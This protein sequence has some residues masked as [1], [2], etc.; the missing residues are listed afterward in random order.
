MSSRERWRGAFVS[1]LLVAALHGCH[2]EPASRAGHGGAKRTGDLNEPGS[3]WTY[4]FED[5]GADERPGGFEFARTGGGPPG[6]WRV[7]A[8]EGAP[9]GAHVLEQ[10]DTSDDEMR[11]LVAAAEMPP[12]SDV[13][14]SVRARPVSG[15]VDQA[16]G[17]VLRYQDE[18]NYYLVRANALEHNVRLYHVKDGKRTQL[19]SWSGSVAPDQWHTLETEAV[20][21][22]LR[23]SFDDRTLIDAHDTTFPNR[24]RVG[25]WTKADSVSQFDDFTIEVVEP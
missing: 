19:R 21:D 5:D 18:S 10:S 7:V 2:G 3:T 17:L 14:V 1:T 4:D 20:G 25:L 12:V 23:V 8:A 15:A 9:S 16:F 22:E 6:R 13:H 24:G 11:F